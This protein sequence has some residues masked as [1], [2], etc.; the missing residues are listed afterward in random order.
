M[1]VLSNSFSVLST[2]ADASKRRRPMPSHLADRGF[3]FLQVLFF[4]PSGPSSGPWLNRKRRSRTVARARNPARGA[5]SIP[6]FF[7]STTNRQAGAASFQLLAGGAG[8]SAASSG[9][10]TPSGRPPS[11]SLPGL[12]PSNLTGAKHL[13]M[14]FWNTP[15]FCL[16]S[17]DCW[18]NGHAADRLHVFAH[19]FLVRANYDIAVVD[20]ARTSLQLLPAL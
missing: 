10:A 1:M 17:L 9:F 11:A 2:V 6:G 4:R 19:L 7:S 20:I 13:H 8:V 14:A 15:M 16:L 12:P 3:D 18:P 5:G